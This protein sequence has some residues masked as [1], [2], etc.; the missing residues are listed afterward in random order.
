V[1]PANRRGKSTAITHSC[2]LAQPKRQGTRQAAASC[3][4]GVV[5]AAADGRLFRRLWH[6]AERVEERRW[7]GF[8]AWR[9]CRLGIDA[10]EAD[11]TAYKVADARLGN[12]QNLGSLALLQPA[13]A[14]RLLE[15]QHQVGP[16]LEVGF[17]LRLGCVRCSV[18][19]R[20]AARKWLTYRGDDPLGSTAASSTPPSASRRRGSACSDSSGHGQGRKDRARDPS[21]LLGRACAVSRL[22]PGIRL[23]SLGPSARA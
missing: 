15:V 20:Y 18:S 16:D 8:L 14:N 23:G 5:P 19:P 7:R 9:A 12:A 6:V 21:A 10:E 3:F 11:P 17:W 22:V 4:P 1:P 2:E 13:R